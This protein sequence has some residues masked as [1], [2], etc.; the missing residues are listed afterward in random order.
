MVNANEENLFKT[1]YGTE[2]FD[3]FFNKVFDGLLEEAKNNLEKNLKEEK[4]SE[5]EDSENEVHSYYHRVADKYDNG[6]HVSHVEKEV[7]DGKVLKNE[8]YNNWEGHTLMGEKSIGNCKE[9]TCK[10][11]KDDDSK[12]AYYKELAEKYKKDFQR[13]SADRN[14]YLKQINVL[15]ERIGKME[16]KFED[17]K[18]LFV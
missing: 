7:K 14:M 3:D 1:L 4:K 5:K 11:K 15:L 12:L 6:D 10:C 17:I 9:D 13:A 16:K 18:K 2:S 8:E